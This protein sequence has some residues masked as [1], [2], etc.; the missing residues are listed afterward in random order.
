MSSYPLTCDVR[1][2]ESTADLLTVLHH[3]DPDFD[4]CLV[5]AWSDELTTQETVTLPFLIALLDEPLVMR[6]PRAGHTAAR[7][8]TWHCSIRSRTG[9]SLNDDDWAEVARAVVDAA[10]IAPEG[11]SMACRWV[12]LRNQP[13]A[14][15]I[16]ATVIRQDGRW[17][18]LHN[19]AL[20]ARSACLD[21]ALSRGRVQPW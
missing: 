14:L 10:S 3:R 5:D 2:S 21:F 17:A 19:D 9:D 11:D 15:D 16:V 1:R 13:R 4:P 12:A 8:L 6:K 20:F 18:R 7:R